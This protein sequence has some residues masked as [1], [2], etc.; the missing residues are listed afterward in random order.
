MVMVSIPRQERNRHWTAAELRAI[1][2]DRNRYE[3]VDGELLVTPAPAPRHQRLLRELFLDLQRYLVANPVG[4]LFFSPADIELSDDTVVQPDLFVIPLSDGESPEEWS[5]V[6]RLL[7]AVEVLSP[8]TARWDRTLKRRLYQR[9][10]VPEY[11]IVD[12]DAR[13]VERWR[14]DDERPEISAEVLEWR[15]GGAK[16][17]L[18]LDLAGMFG[19]VLGE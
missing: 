6:G 19:R 5:E 8:S 1:P 17:P 11:W 15:P 14:P 13:L 12:G 2:D 9:A 16:A 7:L 3:I 4:E 10:G 18:M